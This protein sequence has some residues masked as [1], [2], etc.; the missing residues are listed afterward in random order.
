[1]PKVACE[2]KGDARPEV[3]MDRTRGPTVVPFSFQS[4]MDIRPFYPEANP[5]RPRFR[6]RTRMD[7]HGTLEPISDFSTFEQGL[8]TALEAEYAS[9]GH[10][11]VVEASSLR[12]ERF[13]KTCDM[14][15][16]QEY[17]PEA[18]VQCAKYLADTMG[19]SFKRIVLHLQDCDQHQTYTEALE[20]Q[21][22]LS[23]L[24]AST[25]ATRALEM[26][27]GEWCDSYIGEMALASLHKDLRFENALHHLPYK[28]A[29]YKVYCTW[30]E[31]TQLS[32]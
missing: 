2:L 6:D 23:Y 9:R 4:N 28:G 27:N 12:P 13:D 29:S 22:G 32:K 1:M 15:I 14:Q 17:G 10:S 20:I 24:E 11:I 16:Q 25:L 30:E 7:A 31:T 8:C 3:N 18:Q 19:C 21:K 26:Q 5:G